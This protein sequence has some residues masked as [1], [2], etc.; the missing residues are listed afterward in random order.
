M[1]HGDYIHTLYN[2]IFDLQKEV[3][4]LK[5]Y[6]EV[7]ESNQIPNIPQPDEH[8]IKHSFEEFISSSLHFTDH[9][10]DR[11]RLKHLFTM[12]KGSPF[13]ENLTHPQKRELNTYKAFQALV[14][15]ST[16]AQYRVILNGVSNISRHTIITN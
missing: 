13:F 15:D 7:L 14:M 11:I 3:L 12:Y 16:I 6:I 8:P 9:K 4:T 1:N 2:Q 10:L 5:G